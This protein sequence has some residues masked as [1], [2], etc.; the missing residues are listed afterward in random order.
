MYRKI[1]RRRAGRVRAEFIVIYKVEDLRKTEE[2]HMWLGDREIEAVMLDLSESGMAIF[3]ENDIPVST[4][5]MMKFTLINFSAY[6][7]ERVKSMKIIGQVQ[8]NIFIKDKEYRLGISFLQIRK[9]N[10]IAI[11]NFVKMERGI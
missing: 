1:E 2:V 10:Q 7:E 8:N 9:E 11:S 5:M 4:I 6:D 3:T